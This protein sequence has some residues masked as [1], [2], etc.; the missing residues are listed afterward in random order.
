[1]AVS[2]QAPSAAGSQDQYRRALDR[3][4]T[5]DRQVSQ[6][7]TRRDGQRVPLAASR[8]AWAASIAVTVVSWTCCTSPEPVADVALGAADGIEELA[9]AA[10]P[11]A[12]ALLI[13]TARVVAGSDAG[14]EHLGGLRARDRASGW[15]ARTLRAGQ[16]SSDRLHDCEQEGRDTVYFEPPHDPAEA[17]VR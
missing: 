10:V 16:D 13:L 17:D 7:R 3:A 2:L 5:L 11:G 14:V 4:G 12:G 6:V 1:V 15:G 8:S 9:L